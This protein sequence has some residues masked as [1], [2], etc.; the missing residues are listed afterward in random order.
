MIVEASPLGR[1]VG[2]LTGIRG[3]PQLMSSE[4]ELAEFIR[5]TFRSVWALELALLM[6]EDTE[7]AWTRDDLVTALR[8]SDLIIARSSEEL[9][10][11]GL[12]VVDGEGRACF[13]P[14]SEQIA[15]LMKAAASLYGRSP[16]KVR[17]IIVSAATGGVTAFADAFRIRKN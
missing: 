1:A 13:R 8:A 2:G 3:T 14:A 15:K 6:A 12:I 9:T 11:A 16:D 17:R 7:R 10:A 4:R 5:S